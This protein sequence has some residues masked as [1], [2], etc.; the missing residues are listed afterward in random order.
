MWGLC[1]GERSGEPPW[2]AQVPEPCD[3]MSQRL[4]ILQDKQNP[5]R[6]LWEGEGAP[7]RGRRRLAGRSQRCP[8]E[9]GARPWVTGDAAD[10][11][12]LRSALLRGLGRWPVP[13]GVLRAHTRSRQ[14]CWAP[15]P[16]VEGR[17]RGRGWDC[18]PGRPD[19]AEH[20][21]A[22]GPER[23]GAGVAQVQLPA[24]GPGSPGV[25]DPAGDAAE[26]PLPSSCPVTE[27]AR[28]APSTVARDPAGPQPQ[29]EPCW[30]RQPVS[31]AISGFSARLHSPS[32]NCNQHELQN[33]C[34]ST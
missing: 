3:R 24:P 33:G 17:A 21:G 20:A 1:D 19:L 12:A 22:M 31:V 6:E 34:S 18:A 4:P 16:Q 11:R 2:A 28:A 9:I 26:L 23:T 7:A 32:D 25:N 15:A 29:D 13:D 10:M 14:S 5:G 27:G 30:S 8:A